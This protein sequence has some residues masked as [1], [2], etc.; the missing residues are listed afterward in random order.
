MLALCR[1]PVPLSALLVLIAVLLPPAA[2]AAELHGRVVG[3]TDA[4]R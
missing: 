4:T 2:S 1:S 3:I